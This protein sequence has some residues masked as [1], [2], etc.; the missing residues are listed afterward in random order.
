MSMREPIREQAAEREIEEMIMLE[1]PIK[2]R[3]SSS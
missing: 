1:S 2:N 3:H